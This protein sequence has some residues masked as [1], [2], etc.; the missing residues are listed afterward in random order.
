ML[1]AAADKP[2]PAGIGDGIRS[3][4]AAEN[5]EPV[6]EFGLSNC[7]FCS[8]LLFKVDV[9]ALSTNWYGIER[10]VVGRLGPSMLILFIE[11]L[12]R[13]RHWLLGLN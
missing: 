9:Y 5:I 8:C 13:A 12:T 2:Q 6:I 10:R 7:S 1:P 4:A 11:H 3:N